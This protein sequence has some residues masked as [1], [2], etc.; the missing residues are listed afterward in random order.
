MQD[1][2]IVGGGPAG[3]TAGIYAAR[4]KLK[5]LLITKDF[6]GQI[7]KTGDVEN[8]P[9]VEKATGIEIM[10]KFE[11]HLKKFARPS[12]SSL[13]DEVG[14]D[15][16]IMAPE[17][18]VVVLKNGDNFSIKTKAGKE[19]Q[20]RAVLVASGRNPRPLRV[21]G[22]QELIGRGV[23][24]CSICDAPFFKNK[25]V[26]VVGGGNAAFETVF[27][28]FPYATKIYVLELGT[29]VVADE[30]NQERAK[31]SG[32]V[33]IILGAKIEEIKGRDG[34]EGIVYKNLE[35]GETKE[36]PVG[37]VFIEI[38]SLPA[39]EFLKDI[40]EF[41]EKG[42]IKIDA[43]TCATSAAGIFAAG[44][45][46]DVKY[47]QL[48]IAAGEGAKAGLSAYDYLQRMIIRND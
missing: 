21:K 25:E 28:L 33:E 13:A 10:Q 41:N 7:A 3:I 32:K 12:A 11:A 37:G 29:K 16:E 24:Y 15:I 43:V 46:T 42:E 44:D 47:K 19:F 48:V 26:A 6:S 5:T 17:E 39:N 18:V 20:T 23:S 30:I 36:I 2:I 9:G 1:L 40:V 35:T 45:A 4:K 14:R 22:E 8:W 38:G 31:K 34:V 27:D